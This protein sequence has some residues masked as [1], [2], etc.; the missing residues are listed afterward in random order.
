MKAHQKYPQYYLLKI[1]R[2]DDL[3]EI[4]L[5][6]I[7]NFRL[8]IN[9]NETLND[10]EKEELEILEAISDVIGINTTTSTKGGLDQYFEEK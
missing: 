9:K 4:I 1:F 6:L 8:R 5:L 7:Q 3:K 2:K 10:E